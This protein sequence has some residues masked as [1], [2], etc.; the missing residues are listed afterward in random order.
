MKMFS[1][2]KLSLVILGLALAIIII[3]TS[4]LIQEAPEQQY[5]ENKY[6]E[7]N[8]YSIVLHTK[9]GAYNSAT[10]KPVRITKEIKNQRHI[11][12]I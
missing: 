9:N 4:F 11:L 10:T 8:E 12:D 5:I 6:S 1:T 3:Y 7:N 2:F